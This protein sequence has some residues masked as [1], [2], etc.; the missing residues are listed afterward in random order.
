MTKTKYQTSQA[1]LKR[2]TTDC[3]ERLMKDASA[4]L[5]FSVLEDLF[6]SRDYSTTYPAGL[7]SDLFSHWRDE[8]EAHLLFMASISLAREL[9]EKRKA[10]RDMKECFRSLLNLD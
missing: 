6:R 8:G 3:V 5:S 1:D 4:R 10:Q 2:I 9:E 7:L